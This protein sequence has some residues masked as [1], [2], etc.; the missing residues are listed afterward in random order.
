MITY[1]K[2]CNI[3]YAVDIFERFKLVSVFATT[4]ILI[5]FEQTFY[6][7]FLAFAAYI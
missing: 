1:R 4:N 5:R 3:V 6:S 7:D 2:L